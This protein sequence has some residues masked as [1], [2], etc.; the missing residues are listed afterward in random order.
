MNLMPRKKKENAVVRGGEGSSALGLFR[1]EMNRLMDR[2]FENP[3]N[4]LD[5]DLLP[6]GSGWAPSFDVTDGEKEVTVRAEIPGVDPKDVEVT[7]SGSML[8]VSGEKKDVRE[9][10]G[11]HVWRSE[12]SYGSFCRSVQLPDGVDPEK[13]TAEHANGILTVKVAKS[14]ASAAKRISV[15]AK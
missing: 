11:K 13:V 3:W 2:F 7:V 15:S 5:E 6:S 1:S 9:E 12:C 4:L 14:K 10:K 8:T